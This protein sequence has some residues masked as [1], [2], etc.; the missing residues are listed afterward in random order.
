MKRF[1]LSLVL[2]T[3]LVLPIL[4]ASADTGRQ[5][6]DAYQKMTGVKVV[7]GSNTDVTYTGKHWKEDGEDKYEYIARIHQ[8]PIY[9]EDGSLVDCSWHGSEDAWVIVDNVFS[10]QVIG[11]YITVT[12]QGK[13]MSW[14]P[15]VMIDSKE[16]VAKGSPK[17]ISDP[18]NENY[19]RNT[20]E[21]DYGVCVRRVR[22]IEGL[23]QETWT[24][25]KDPKGNVWIRDHAQTQQGFTWAIE[26]Y[27][28]DADGNPIAVNEYKQVAASVM[29]SAKYPVTI[30]PTEV[31]V[32]SA[33][34]GQVKSGDGAY[35]FIHDFATGN[36][37]ATTGINIYIGQL[38]AGA[39]YR[40][41]R[42]YV[43]FD[44]SSL[45]DG[46]VIT[47]ATLNLYGYNDQSSTDF[48]ITIQNGQPDYPHDPLEAGD[49]DYTK[50]SGD[51]G[52]LTTAGF[53]TAG[54]NTITL[55]ADGRSWI[56]KAGT[57]KLCLRSSRDISST[58]PTGVEYVIVH[59]Y[60]KGVGFRPYLEVTYVSSGPPDVSSVAATYVTK[61]TARVNG[62]LDSDGGEATTVSFIYHPWYN[63]SWSYC[64]ELTL[65]APIVGQKAVMITNDSVNAEFWANVNASGLDIVVCDEDFVTPLNREIITIN[66]TTSELEMYANVSD[67]TERLYLYFGNPTANISDDFATYED[68]PETY[69][70][71]VAA[72]ADGCWV[73]N[74]PTAGTWT[75]Q[76]D[77][78]SSLIGW[79]NNAEMKKCGG[80]FIWRNAN[81]PKSSNVVLANITWESWDSKANND[82]YVRYTGELSGTPSVFSNIAN[83]QERRGVQAGG[84]DD[85]LRTVTQ[86]DSGILPAWVVDTTYVSPE[87]KTIVQE[88]VNANAMTDIS[89]FCDDHEGRSTAQNVFRRIKTYEQAA[90][91]APLLTVE[92][93][94]KLNISITETYTPTT[95][96]S[97]NTGDSFYT[98]L[99]GLTANTLYGFRAMGTQTQGTDYGAWLFFDTSVTLGAPSN[100]TCKPGS[101]SITLSWVKGGN[102]SYTY[103][104]YKTGGYPTGTADGNAIALQS[105]VDYV[106]TGLTSGVTYY[107]KLWGEDAGDYSATNSTTACTTY[108]GYSEGTPVPLPTT[109]TSGWSESPNGSVVEN[110]PLYALGN[111]EADEVGVPHNTWWML[112]ALG[113]LVCTGLFIYT[114]SR[115]LLA[116]L[117]AMIIFGVIMAQAGLF[118]IWTMIIFGL[119]GIG[120]GWKEIR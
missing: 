6:A 107:Y 65:P 84:G 52:S 14:N 81:I 16:Y 67:G 90:G 68:F 58:V 116:A 38:L 26:P 106:H 22:V 53:S 115:N 41:Y 49:Y 20:L 45:P 60:E 24:F 91:T 111:L 76:L 56:N 37:V 46:G 18:I 94:P 105:G 61:T 13:S 21:W 72:S 7:T 55:N 19:K 64:L 1:V 11:S 100:V 40:I 43:Y 50:Y 35:A 87:L 74:A 95:T 34:D 103:I 10:A 25:D 108:A 30:D 71:R 62:Y 110:N 120:F 44:T 89:I 93:I 12:Y 73:Y 79:A 113:G 47:A 29:A 112:L 97:K 51:G 86:I 66:T 99:T 88:Q 119:M 17:V 101:N 39:N 85:T 77:G 15:V 23:I 96:Q 104:R 31:F 2:L 83:Y 59:A 102:T 5:A 28:Y 92:Y 9:N 48:N 3:M 114:R 118:P 75:I 78:S 4:P 57:T 27:G 54:Y 69:S 70:A 8:A 42:G 32:T 80:G 63:T 109:D 33:S 36:E 82:C 117:G 98:N